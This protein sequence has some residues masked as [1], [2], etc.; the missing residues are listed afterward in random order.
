MP[1]SYP[2]EHS[3]TQW[4]TISELGASVG[5]PIDASQ[6]RTVPSR[7]AAMAHACIHLLMGHSLARNMNASEHKRWGC[8]GAQ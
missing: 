7:Q 3:A 5:A 1:P 2:L 8:A 6:A 4:F